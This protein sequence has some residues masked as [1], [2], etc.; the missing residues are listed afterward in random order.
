MTTTRRTAYLEDRANPPQCRATWRGKDW[1][2]LLNLAHSSV[3]AAP[4]VIPQTT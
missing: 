1:C 3:G 4:S 2:E